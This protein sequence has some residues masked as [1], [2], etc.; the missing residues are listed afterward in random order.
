MLPKSSADPEIAGQRRGMGETMTER[1]AL[2]RAWEFT[3][4]WDDAFL[5]GEGLGV[6]PVELPHTCRQTPYDYF[7]ESIYQMVCGYRR[8][9]HVPEAWRGKRVFLTVGAAGHSAE[10]YCGGKKLAEH[11]CG[12]TA[13]RVE[14]TDALDYGGETLLA[15]RVDSREQQN[16]P[17]FGYVIDYMTYG[18]LYRE[19]TLEVKEQSGIDDVFVLP[20]IPEGKGL[21]KGRTSAQRAGAVTFTGTVN[22]RV[23]LYG[24]EPCDDKEFS[25]CQKVLLGER[26]LAEK[27]TPMTNVSLNLEQ[28]AAL[29]LELPGAK[30]WDTLSPALYTL[31]TE[32]WEGETVLDRTE[33]TFGFR[34]AVFTADGFYLNGR[35]L[36]LV[37][38]NRHQSYPYVGYAMP[39]SMQRLDADIL[40][41]ELGLNAVRTSHYPQSQHFIDRCDELG[42]LVFTEIPGWQHI[43]DADWQEQAVRNT[44]DMV[45]QYRNHPSIIL[46]GVRINESV[47]NDALYERTNAVA[48]QLDGT[49]QTGG[50]RC[51]KKSRLL[52]D[53]YTYNDF[54]HEGTNAGCEKKKDIT[55]EPEKPYLIS[56]YCGHMY[57]TKT[58]DSEL[59]RQEHALRHAN[60][61][62]AVAGEKDIAGSFGWCMFDYNTHRDFG[63]G[64]RICYHGVMDMF[65]NPKLA[66]DVYAAAQDEIPVLSVSSGMDIGEH[67]AG[68]RGRLFL[69]TNADE[70]RLYKNDRF[71]RSYT[72]KNSPYKNM[73]RPPIEVD[74]FLGDQIAENEPFTPRQ[75]AMVKDLLNYT[76]RFGSSHLPPKILAEAGILMARYHMSFDDAYALYGKYI[77]DWGAAAKEYRFEAV[78]DGK[79]VKTVCRAPVSSLSLSARVDHTELVEDETYDVALIRIAMTDQNGNVVPFYQGGVTLETEGEIEL[80]GPATAM[81]RGG[82]GGTYVKTKGKV[83]Q[84]ALILKNEQSVPVRIEFT[85]RTADGK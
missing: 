71:I 26:I 9:L 46:W 37:G 58:Y 72:H 19:V 70:V 18:G 64:D 57:P 55:S 44:E 10:V 24:A 13:F 11:H 61:L 20:E 32:L 15:I 33:T 76:T 8:T 79:V 28:T 63:S 7:D 85:I 77:G 73:N 69:F 1:I 65:R 56:E 23:R 38:L 43:G 40:K 22:S 84:A 16:I 48:R 75:A 2:N 45:R 6:V 3:E 74:D 67:P 17:P 35:K 59:H 78:K 42:L 60:V 29:N 53:V 82:C 68:N 4:H 41:R 50:V 25:L 5:R 80:I 52:E 21:L 62:N 34:R 14:L 81:L 51:I 36:K 47:D 27:I 54:V 31:V 66:A 49:R 39:R 30:L 12:Y 83:G